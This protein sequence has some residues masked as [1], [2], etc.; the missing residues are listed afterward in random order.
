M[1]LSYHKAKPVS[2]AEVGYDERWQQERILEDPTILGLGDV[3]IV[4]RERK[5]TSGGRI[6]FLLSDPE[7]N[8]MYEVEIMLGRL[9]ESHIIR[10]I[11]YWDVERRRWPNRDHKAVI[12]AEEITNRFFNVIGLFNRAIPMIAVQLNASQVED[13]II[14]NF[15]RVL[16]VYE[17]TEEEGEEAEPTDREWWER[18]SNR[19]SFSIVDQCATLL[20]NN[21]HTPRMTYNKHH[22]A[23][24]GPRQNFC[25]FHPRKAQSHC[26]LHLKTG[27][28]N[29]SGVTSKIEEVGISV[30]PHRKDIIRVII[31]PHEMKEHEAVIREALRM[32]AQVVGGDPA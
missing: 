32:A 6:D 21:G 15:T 31:T 8:T 30:A 13:K 16:D 19:Q 14:L 29:L 24:G 23:M 1:S 18:R 22:I 9:D 4:Q 27:E 7:T 12:V 20:S 25:W 2:L 28:A 17:Q 26:H 3:S 10:T 5:Q 11:E